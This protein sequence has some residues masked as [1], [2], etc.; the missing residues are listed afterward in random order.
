MTTSGGNKQ[1]EG[2][3]V[4]E[5][6]VGDTPQAQAAA[7][8]AHLQARGGQLQTPQEKRQQR[9][10][11]RM[12][13]DPGD[14]ATMTQMTDQAFR[15]TAPSR[16]A[17]QLTHILDVQGIPRF[18]STFDRT[19]LKGFQSFGNYLPGVAVPRVKEKMREETANVV[20]PAEPELLSRHL[21][22]RRRT[23][24]RMNVNF[25]GEALLGEEDALRRLQSYLAALQLPEIEVI[26]VKATTLYSQ[27]TPIGRRHALRVLCDR[28]ELLYR[29]SVKATYER[30]TGN[31]VPKFVYLDMEEYRDLAI[32]V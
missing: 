11:E 26:S 27:V 14:K 4:L 8:A 28:L 25:L 18:F 16:V 10:L 22:E 7:L 19:L 2:S 1:S 5:L 24:L 29:A 31:T 30:P 9:E 21:R 15:A 32:T 17:D 23:G 13:N 6:A 3:P 20:L 12:V